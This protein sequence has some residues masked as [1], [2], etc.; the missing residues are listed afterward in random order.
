MHEGRR[1]LELTE[2]RTVV[3]LPL[4]T[5]LLLLLLVAPALM[6]SRWGFL[7][8]AHGLIAFRPALVCNGAAVLTLLA[9][10]SWRVAAPSRGRSLRLS[11]LIGV[12]ALVLG[13]IGDSALYFALL[14]CC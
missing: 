3:S 9:L 13:A 11:L 10:L 14:G 5:L 6:V 2:G 12:A 7:Y 8:V 1:R 4:V